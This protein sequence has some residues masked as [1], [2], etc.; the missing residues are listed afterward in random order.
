MKR[1]RK[2]ILFSLLILLVIV[3]VFPLISLKYLKKGLSFR[4][5]QLELLDQLGQVSDFNATNIDG[6]SMS[7]S[8]TLGRV[9]VFSFDRM[10]CD[11]K[12]SK[13]IKE[14]VFK[15]INQDDFR[16]VIL[17]DRSN[18][19]DWGESYVAELKDND[20][21]NSQLNNLISSS[22]RSSHVALVDRQGEIRRVYDL[23]RKEDI[24][25]LVTHTTLLMPPLKKRG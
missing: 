24:E 20:D 10:A 18:C 16:H 4:Q 13:T 17:K 25:S 5:D 2:S 6:K 7:K 22:D 11:P 12:F 3:V 23:T 19:S 21:I 8:L 9:T 14:Y 1:S 15:F